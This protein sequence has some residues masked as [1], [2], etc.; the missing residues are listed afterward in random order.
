MNHLKY[1]NYKNEN[2]ETKKPLYDE[3]LNYTPELIKKVDGIKEKIMTHFKTNTTKIP[4]NQHMLA[5]CM[6][7]KRN[8]ENQK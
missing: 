6:G 8:E 4:V 5:M 2:T 3:L 7:V 1:Q